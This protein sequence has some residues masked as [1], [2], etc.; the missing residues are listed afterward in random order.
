VER[1][2][3]V[4]LGSGTARLVVYHYETGAW[5]RLT[6]EVRD[7]VRL[8]EGFAHKGEL[9][10]P[11][12]ER[13]L[14]ALRMYA[15]YAQATNLGQLEVIATSAVREAANQSEF[16][17]RLT[18]LPL[19]FHVLSGEQEAQHGTRAVANSFDFADAWV[20]DLGGGSAQLS[21]MRDRRWTSGRAFPLGGVRLT[22]LFFK[23]DPPERDQVEALEK[24]VRREMRVALN[25]VKA[26][27][28]PFVAMGGTIRNLARVIQKEMDY[29]L[30][31]L[32]GF[33]LERRAL[34]GLTQK[35]QKLNAKGRAQ[36]P[37]IHP[38]RAD[39][40]LAGAIVYCTVM[41]EADLEEIIISGQGVREG[42]F[43]GHFM[44]SPHL[45]PDVRRFSVQNL[46]RHYPQPQAHTER[47]RLLS[48]RLF[49]GLEELHQYSS[50]E[51]RL[52][53]DAAQLHDIGMAVNYY[54]HHKHS[55]YLVTSAA[56][57]GLTPR[58]Q[59]LLALLVQY[60]RKGDPKINAYKSI[61]LDG[62]DQRLLR[63]SA[64][65]RL[66]EYLE[67]SRAGRVQD[68]SVQIEKKAVRVT[69]RAAEPP[70]VELREA[71]K[72]ANIF[73]KAFG[74]ELVLEAQVS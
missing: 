17:T 55:A 4:D 16:L 15:D 33:A 46:F 5:F 66:A 67:R 10:R 23:S 72:Q 49:E 21:Q 8:G 47:V 50:F 11:A 62:D 14:E 38:D 56:I 41:R 58:E 20:M 42:A 6:D 34:E 59:A 52:L 53:D 65:L 73:K 39:V 26:E 35:L 54:D 2:G 43:Y 27:P 7:P 40:I 3:I 68:L 9:E 13:A 37:G 48:R 19:R 28:A 32:H 12:I 60:H 18:G 74:R 64:C 30:D 24:F 69:L 22:E 70:R 36:V 61:L 1:I 25:R 44:P 45:I 31:V 63:L 29:P 51:A 71:G 57:P